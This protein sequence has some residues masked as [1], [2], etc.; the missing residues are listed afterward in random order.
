MNYNYSAGPEPLLIVS[1][2]KTDF[3]VVHLAA[4]EKKNIEIKKNSRGF[5]FGLC[6]AKKGGGADEIELIP[7]TWL[8][9]MFN[10]LFRR[11]RASL[12]CLWKEN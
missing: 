5:E 11:T 3:D 1:G 10:D 9:E 6:V 7:Y 4:K 8:I 12:D 2:K